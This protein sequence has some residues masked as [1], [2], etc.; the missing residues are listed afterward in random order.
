MPRSPPFFSVASR[1][2]VVATPEYYF[3]PDLSAFPTRSRL[4]LIKWASCS[5]PAYSHLLPLHCLCSTWLSPSVCTSVSSSPY[6]HS[7]LPDI[8][9]APLFSLPTC[10][11]REFLSLAL[12]AA[13]LSFAASLEL[14]VNDAWWTHSHWAIISEVAQVNRSDGWWREEGMEG[15]TEDSKSHVFHPE[16]F[17][18]IV[19]K[20][21]SCLCKTLVGGISYASGH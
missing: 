7:L 13:S 16:A 18:Y 8:A 17:P 3:H 1:S 21:R 9:A 4:W 15:V 5:P 12:L 2:A 20:T 19:T 6:S 10:M 14:L 11:N